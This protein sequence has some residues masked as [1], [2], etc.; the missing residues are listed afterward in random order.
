MFFE[1]INRVPPRL[2]KLRGTAL[3]MDQIEAILARTE[4]LSSGPNEFPNA[5]AQARREFM[6]QH[7]SVNGAWVAVGG[8]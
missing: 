7:E 2:R 8:S 5:I 3:A 6:E 4:E 1:S